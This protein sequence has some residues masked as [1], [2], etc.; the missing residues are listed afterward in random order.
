MHFCHRRN[1]EHIP[2]LR[3]F[4]SSD[5][6]QLVTSS[7][8]SSSSSNRCSARR[9]FRDPNNGKSDGAGSGLCDRCGRI[10]QLDRLSQPL[11]IFAQCGVVLSCCN[12]TPLVRRPGLFRRIAS[13]SLSS[14]WQY[15]AAFTV[16]PGGRKSTSRIPCMSQ[17]PWP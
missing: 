6:N 3:N 14:V 8:S 5:C 11:V 9:C 2:T 17:K 12:V 10:S 4:A 7:V 15:L 1:R 16:S 13:L